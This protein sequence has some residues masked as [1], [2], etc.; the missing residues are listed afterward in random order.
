MWNVYVQAIVAA[1]S[2]AHST[3]IRC[4]CT[5]NSFFD[6][7]HIHTLTEVHI[8]TIAFNC[9]CTVGLNVFALY[10]IDYTM[11]ADSIERSHCILYVYAF[12]F[13]LC[14]RFLNIFATCAFVN[15]METHTKF[16]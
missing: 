14:N 16:I 12:W 7:V 6:I 3:F 9:L 2:F 4:E 8:K 15:T 1:V 10:S 5:R 11:F 13:G